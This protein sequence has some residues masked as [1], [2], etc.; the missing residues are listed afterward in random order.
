MS[1]KYNIM[2]NPTNVIYC[3]DN[4]RIMSEMPDES[5]DL[6]Y[7]D[8]PFF[9]GKNY[10]VIWKDGTEERSFKDTEWYRVECPKCNREVVK[11]EL[12]CP[13]CGTDL[14][15]AKVTRKNDIYAY[16]DWMVPRL[17]E[18]HRILKPTG[19]IYLHVDHH[20][21]HYLKVEMDRIFGNGDPSKGVKCFRNEIIWCYSGA[22]NASK[23]FPKKHDN[24]LWYSKG[25]NYTFNQHDILIPSRSTAKYY[26][27]ENGREYTK[28]GGK[29]YYRKSQ[30]GKIPEDYWIDI[31]MLHHIAK[32]RLGY[33]TQKPLALLERIIKASSNPG[34]VVFD[35]FCGCGTSIDAAK[36]LGRKY[37][38]IDISPT[39]CMVIADRI[40]HPKPIIGMKYTDDQYMAMEPHE[41]Q[42]IVC[43]QMHAKNTSPDPKKASGPDDGIDG[44]VKSEISTIGFAGALI[45]V[46]RSE[47]KNL[48]KNTIKNFESTMQHYK[49][50]NR[51]PPSKNGFVVAI[52]FGS[53]ARKQAK[54][55]KILDLN[56]ILV[57]AK[58]LHDFNFDNY[59]PKKG[60]FEK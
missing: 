54:A 38:G 31:N 42:N 39:S 52:S 49:P 28:K 57:E 27:D 60:Y 4:L 5:V 24:I 40:K 33:P 36:E 53:G 48:N 25:K 22:N 51:K 29:I 37:I 56:I 12:F 11:A 47:A 18:M 2:E 45:Q 16:I 20:A 10:E 34:D 19:S 6:I 23:Y 8:P 14:S 3:G 55:A 17:T 58:E 41:F 15:G 1:Y 43:N 46:K 59:I 13:V 35:P 32:E 30:N 26:K 7:L 44:I 50:L 9:S 21:V